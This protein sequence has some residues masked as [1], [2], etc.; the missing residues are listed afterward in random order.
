MAHISDYHHCTQTAPNWNACSFRSQMDH[1]SAAWA[2]SLSIF[3]YLHLCS[4]QDRAP[5]LVQL[6]SNT[7]CQLGHL[8]RCK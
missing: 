6:T 5:F 2:C 4:G 8:Q 7:P 1:P 3:A